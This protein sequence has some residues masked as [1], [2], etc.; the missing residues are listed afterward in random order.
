MAPILFSNGTL[1][2]TEVENRV[3]G[4]GY[5]DFGHALFGEADSIH[6]TD[7]IDWIDWD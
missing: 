4:K 1:H 5:E 3:D 2:E 6:W 7:K